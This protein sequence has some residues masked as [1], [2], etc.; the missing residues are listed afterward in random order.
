MHSGQYQIFREMVVQARKESKLTQVQVA[1]MLGKPQSYVS[2]V[3]L[4]ERRL[5][6]TEFVDFANVIGID[7]IKFVKAYQKQAKGVVR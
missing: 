4:G 7:I 5:D 2:K 6:F 3:E 1:K